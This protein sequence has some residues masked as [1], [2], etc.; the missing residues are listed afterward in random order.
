MSWSVCYVRLFAFS[1]AALAL[2]AC[3]RLSLSD[4]TMFTMEPKLGEKP[5]GH[6]PIG[7]ENRPVTTEDVQQQLAALDSQITNLKRALEIMSP[8]AKVEEFAVSSA[9]GSSLYAEAP[10][11]PQ[12][13][14]LFRWSDACTRFTTPSTACSAVEPVRAAN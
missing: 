2:S 1:L 9:A 10:D 8:K 12:A 7:P 3:A 5:L 11:L 4:P 6:D 13:K 14:S